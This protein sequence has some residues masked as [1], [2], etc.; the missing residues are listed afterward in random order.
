METLVELMVA[1]MELMEASVEL[2]G[3]SVR[4]MEASARLMEAW[5]DKT[6]VM[7]VREVLLSKSDVDL[8]V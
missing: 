7:E 1:S 8:E 5:L 6:D 2:I 4:L 3:P